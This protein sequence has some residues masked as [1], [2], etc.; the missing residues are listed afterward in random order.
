MSYLRNKGK[1]ILLGILLIISLGASASGRTANYEL[2]VFGMNIGTFKVK[3]QTVGNEIRTEG[4]T[5]VKVKLIFTYHIKYVQNSLYR[6]GILQHS[7]VETI[8]NDELNS[9][10]WL[11]KQNDNYL[12]V[13]EQD[14]TTITDEINYSGSLLYFFEPENVHSMYKER[15]GEHNSLEKTGDHS[16]ISTD[17]NGKTANEYEYKNGILTHAKLKHP[18][19]TIQMILIDQTGESKTG[20]ANTI[21]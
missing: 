2:R 6:D 15:T 7:H 17:E 10:T 16:Y 1:I 11:K 21:D 18:L 20:T 9:D 14:S 8:K 13:N 12:L 3:Q 5:E 4:I 19:A